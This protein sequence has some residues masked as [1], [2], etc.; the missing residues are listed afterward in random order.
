[1]KASFRLSRGNKGKQRDG[2]RVSSII[3]EFLENGAS[4]SVQQSFNALGQAFN[5]LVDKRF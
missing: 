5:L 4:P 2:S 3:Q 1:M